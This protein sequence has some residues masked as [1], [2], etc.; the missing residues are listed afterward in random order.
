MISMFILLVISSYPKRIEFSWDWSQPFFFNV[1][2]IRA[3]WSI[4]Q[5]SEQFIYILLR[6]LCH[7]FHSVITGITNPSG[8]I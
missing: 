7:D 5:K 1:R 3:F 8:D 4:F 2:Y 6:T